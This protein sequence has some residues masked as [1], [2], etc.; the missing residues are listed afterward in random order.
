MFVTPLNR[1][2]KTIVI[3]IF[4]YGKNIKINILNRYIYICVR[5]NLI[6]YSQCPYKLFSLLRC[7]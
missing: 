2:L 3:L 1:S 7:V 6:Y 5:N 4:T